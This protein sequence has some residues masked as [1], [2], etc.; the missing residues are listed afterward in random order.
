[1]WLVALFRGC[2]QI[3]KGIDGAAGIAGT[4]SR[5]S[6]DFIN[7]VLIHMADWEGTNF[8]VICPTQPNMNDVLIAVSQLSVFLAESRVVACSEC[9][10]NAQVRFEYLLDQVRGSNEQCSY[11]LPFPATCPLCNSPITET[12]FVQTKSAVWQDRAAAG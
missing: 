3:S 2:D 11:I 6:Y 9:S 1:L 7:S 12:S 4:M 10:T 5:I 8:G